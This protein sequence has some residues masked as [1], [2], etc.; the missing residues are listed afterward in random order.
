MIYPLRQKSMT[1]MQKIGRHFFVNLNL[2]TKR[3]LLE[4]ILANLEIHRAETHITSYM[5][6]FSNQRTRIHQLLSLIEMN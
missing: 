5:F 1:L 4:I 3:F 6:Q 2:H